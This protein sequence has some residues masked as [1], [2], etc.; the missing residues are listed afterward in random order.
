VVD[1][2]P[3]LRR[4]V[5]TML[6]RSGLGLT[7]ITAQDGT[8]ALSMLEIER[9]DIVVLDVA[10]PG[11]DGFEVCRRMRADPL[12][13][14]VP[15]LLLTARD[16]TED[17]ARGFREGA[18]DYVVKP[19]RSEELIAR[20]RRMIHRTYGDLDDTSIPPEP[21]RSSRAAE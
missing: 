21:Q 10:M 13:A 4:I 11:M 5:R 19:F 7:V 14:G 6:E 3:D 17:V 2:D 1:D 20:I 12:T 8:E 18:D 9:P 15:V 16:T